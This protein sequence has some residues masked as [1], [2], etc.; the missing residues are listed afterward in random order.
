MQEFKAGRR[1]AQERRPPKRLPLW[2]KT[3]KVSRE[4]V[5]IPTRSMLGLVVSMC[6]CERGIPV[7]TLKSV[8]VDFALVLF[9]ECIKL[10]AA[11]GSGVLVAV[12]VVG[13]RALELASVAH[14]LVVA[15]RLEALVA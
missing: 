6:S 10:V 5:S 1:L 7:L 14:K 11:H 8:G 3:F 2:D 12:A 9:K 4:A 13:R 15:L